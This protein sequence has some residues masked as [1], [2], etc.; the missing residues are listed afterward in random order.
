MAK[1]LTD[2][3]LH[4]GYLIER[5]SKAENGRSTRM[6]LPV[7]PVTKNEGLE[8]DSGHGP[9]EGQNLSNPPTVPT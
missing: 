1:A 4:E 8:I 3:L 9:Q 5:P 6:F 7:F 2:I